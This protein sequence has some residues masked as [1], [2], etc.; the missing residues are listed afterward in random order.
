MDLQEELYSEDEISSEIIAS[1]R[2]KST[3]KY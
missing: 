2:G 3:H 1:H